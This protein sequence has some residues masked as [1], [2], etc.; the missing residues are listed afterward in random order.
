MK[1]EFVMLLLGK[2]QI[3]WWINKG[4]EKFLMYEKYYFC[5]GQNRAIGP[6]LGI[7]DLS[8]FVGFQH[9]NK[10]T[11]DADLT[12]RFVAWVKEPVQGKFL[13]K[14]FFS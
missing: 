10:Q 6:K 3:F 4:F 5:S 12:V 14:I 1:L 7:P 11:D 9:D 8:I 13:S 2:E